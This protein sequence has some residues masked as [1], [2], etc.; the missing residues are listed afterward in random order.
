MT[1]Q[2]TRRTEDGDDP[3]KRAKS[4]DVRCPSRGR[5]SETKAKA[6]EY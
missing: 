1:A 6:V 4:V 5:R 3:E 2:T